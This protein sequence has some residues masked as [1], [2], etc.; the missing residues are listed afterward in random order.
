VAAINEGR[1]RAAEGYETPVPR[2]AVA[3]YARL[4]RALGGNSAGRHAS[5]GAHDEDFMLYDTSQTPG[6]RSMDDMIGEERP[7]V[8]QRRPPRW[9]NASPPQVSGTLCTRR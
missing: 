4:R 3:A 6:G 8:S 2:P 9:T 1:P 7:P 5:K